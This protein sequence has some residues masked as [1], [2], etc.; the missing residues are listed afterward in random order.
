M[1]T[2]LEAPPDPKI[3]E[4]AHSEQFELYKKLFKELGIS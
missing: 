2:P 1:D 4:F 3:E